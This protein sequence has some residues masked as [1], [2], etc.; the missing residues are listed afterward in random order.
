MKQFKQRVLESQDSITINDQVILENCILEIA[1]MVKEK[2]KPEGDKSY[3]KASYK[4]YARNRMLTEYYE[5]DLSN[6]LA[7]KTEP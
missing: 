3:A 6:N 2:I 1:E 7:Y 4:S 5:I